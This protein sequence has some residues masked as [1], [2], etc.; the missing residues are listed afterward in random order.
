MKST[1]ALVVPVMAAA[2]ALANAHSNLHHVRAPAPAS[3]T[4]MPRVDG[5]TLQGC[6][7][8][9]GNMTSVTVE[10]PQ[11]LSSG[12]CT[13]ACKAKK[14][15][16]DKEMCGG[17]KDAYSVY[18][19]GFINGLAPDNYGDSSSSSSSTTQTSSSSSSTSASSTTSQVAETDKPQKSG[20]GPNTA[21][22][23][24]GVVVGV[25]VA[26]AIIGGIIF[27][28]RRK[29]NAEIEEEHRRNAAVNAFISGS[30][31][32]ST[33]GGISITDSRLD[34][35]MAHRRLSD[36]SIADNQDYSR[37]ILRVTNA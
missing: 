10:E 37:K 8:S 32:P 29:R 31:P 25:V 16:F 5:A 26:A 12:K 35:V 21:A 13:D 24:A 17:L 6:F 2:G 34:P 33:S 30:K 28:I 14:I 36:G 7:S 19:N 4:A 18:N 27:F 23:A 15:G 11:Y 3:E 22:I 9:V 20:G 1:F